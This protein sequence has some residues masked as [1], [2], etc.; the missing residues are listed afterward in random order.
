MNE[1]IV[2]IDPLEDTDQFVVVIVQIDVGC[3]LSQCDVIAVNCIRK[4]LVKLEPLAII[5]QHFC[6]F[7]V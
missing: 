6:I 3:V 5:Y 1:V 4:T 7:D 2:V